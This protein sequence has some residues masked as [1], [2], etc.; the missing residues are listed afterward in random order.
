MRAGTLGIV[1]MRS[2][3][4]RRFAHFMIASALPNHPRADG[5][6]DERVD[7]H[8]QQRLGPLGPCAELSRRAFPF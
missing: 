6:R 7:T 2:R 3:L 4:V 1:E 5:F 8:R